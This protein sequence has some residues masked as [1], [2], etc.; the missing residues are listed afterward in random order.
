MFVN[1]FLRWGTL[2]KCPRGRSESAGTIGGFLAGAITI[3]WRLVDSRTS[4]ITKF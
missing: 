1:V 4:L 2:R 3:R